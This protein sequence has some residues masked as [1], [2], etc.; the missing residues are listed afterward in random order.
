MP[1]FLNPSCSAA[2]PHTT[3]ATAH[4]R[5]ARLLLPVCLPIVPPYTMMPGR[6]RSRATPTGAH[7][8]FTT[9]Y[10]CPCQRERVTSPQLG[11]RRVNCFYCDA[12]PSL[13]RRHAARARLRAS[14]L[15]AHA[16]AVRSRTSRRLSAP[17]NSRDPVPSA[18]SRLGWLTLAATCMSVGHS[19]RIW[20]A[21]R[22]RQGGVEGMAD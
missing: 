20:L 14:S 16:Y 1:A 15:L 22:A 13:H 12:T 17:Q 7:S 9:I 11:S 19:D 8:L 18:A 10:T 5:G 2:L 3:A 21:Q 6:L 4:G